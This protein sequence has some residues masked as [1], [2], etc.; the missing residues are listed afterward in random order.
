MK[1]GRSIALRPSWFCNAFLVKRAG[2]WLVEK[3]Q[4]IG[5]A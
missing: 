1:E 2:F 5:E 3:M 4:L